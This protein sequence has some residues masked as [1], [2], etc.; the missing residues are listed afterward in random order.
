[1]SKYV[2]QTA[3]G[4]SIKARLI[5]K[6][7]R[8]VATVLTHYGNTGSVLVNVFQREEAAKRSIAARA[9]AGN[10]FKPQEWESEGRFQWARAGGYGY[11]K[12]T[13]A[14]RGMNIDGH[15]LTDHCDRTKAPKPPKGRRTYP[16]GTAPKGYRFSNYCNL[17]KST[18]CR[19]NKWDFIEKAGA[20]LGYEV[21]GGN[22]TSDEQ[23]QATRELA[24][25]LENEWLQSEDCEAGYSDC[26]RLSGLE[27]L[28]SLG[29]SVL[30][31][32]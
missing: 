22:R 29:Y 32:L 16:Y 14:L 2:S 11:D 26:Y 18:G 6:G 19:M 30:Q 31:V 20:Q 8:E 28:E 27:Y 10:A 3:A 1:M 21:G 4:K 7:T 15:D 5:M 25:R 12:E 24:E 23:W 9:K 13:A 17:S